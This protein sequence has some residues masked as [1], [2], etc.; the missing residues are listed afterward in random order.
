MSFILFCMPAITNASCLF[1]NLLWANNPNWQA[2]NMENLFNNNLK[3]LPRIILKDP[4]NRS[5]TFDFES[6]INAVECDAVQMFI[7]T[8]EKKYHQVMHEMKHQNLHRSRKSRCQF[9]FSYVSLVQDSSVNVIR[10]ID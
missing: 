9:V 5:T 6:I 1:C 7:I 10:Y 3:I 2:W 4:T 8:W